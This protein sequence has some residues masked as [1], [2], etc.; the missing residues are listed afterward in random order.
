MENRELLTLDLP[1]I[2]KMRK[3]APNASL[4]NK[5]KKQLILKMSCFFVC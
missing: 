3:N 2:M 5:H 4:L 1:L